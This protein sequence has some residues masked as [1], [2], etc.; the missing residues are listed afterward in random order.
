MMTQAD[1]FHEGT[2]VRA[3]GLNIYYEEYGAGQPLLL[4]HGGAINGRVA[5]GPYIPRLLQHFRLIIPDSRG[6]GRTDN[7]DQRLSYRVMADDTNALCQ[8]LSLEQPLIC[9]YSDGGQIAIDIGV[10]YP[11]LA[12]GLVIGAASHRFSASYFEFIRALG[13]VAPGEVDL[14]RAPPEL[15][16][17]VQQ[18]H[19]D[20]YGPEYW[21]TLLQ[22]LSTMFLTQLEYTDA[23]LERMTTPTL[24]VI[25]DRDDAFFDEVLGMYRLIPGAELAVAPGADHL[26]FLTKADLFGPLCLDFLL[27]HVDG[28]ARG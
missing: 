21:K 20:V 16:G 4:I 22:H 2:Y 1:P 6:H 19:S 14:D 28:A 13:F 25:G 17:L 7:P 18:L 24:L 26:S 5:W 9:G 10:R 12:R 8:A 11:R 3:N 27:R 23:D 15:I